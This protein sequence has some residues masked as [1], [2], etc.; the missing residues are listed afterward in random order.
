MC[1]CVRKQ[2]KR[3][4]RECVSPQATHMESLK[5]AHTSRHTRLLLTWRVTRMMADCSLTLKKSQ[6]L[7]SKQGMRRACQ[8]HTGTDSFPGCSSRAAQ[9]SACPPSILPLPPPLCEVDV[10][11]PDDT[12]QMNTRT[13][14]AANKPRHD[15]E[16]LIHTHAAILR[17]AAA[18]CAVVMDTKHWGTGLAWRLQG[19]REVGHDGWHEGCQHRM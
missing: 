6:P 8:Y 4:R 16:C 14:S 2:T 17:A 9:A 12:R 10:L 3:R 13:H 7:T 19:V 11:S 1:V 15:P 18:A 5:H